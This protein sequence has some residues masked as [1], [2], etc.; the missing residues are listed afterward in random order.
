MPK[1]PEKYR[2]GPFWLDREK[3]RPNWLICWYDEARGR[4]KR[5]STGTSDLQSA[6]Q[7]L[8]EHHLKTLNPVKTKQ[9][10]TLR[11]IIM[12]YW[13]EHGQ[14]IHNA[15]GCKI[16]LG[17]FDNFITWSER[18]G[19]FPQDPTLENWTPGIETSFVQ[20]LKDNPSFTE[21]KVKNSKGEVVEVIKTPRTRSP[22]TINR[23][24]DDVRA[25]FNYAVEKRL[26]KWAPKFKRIPL[27][28]DEHD[29]RKPRLSMD[30]MADLF[31]YAFQ[32]SDRY[33]LQAYL[34]AAVNTLARPEAIL[35][36]CADPSRQQ[37]DL[38]ARL[39]F[40]N[41]K[42]RQQTKKYRPVVPVNDY[43]MTWLSQAQAN[44]QRNID[45]EDFTSS[46]YL[47]E[48][49]GKSLSSIRQTW[50]KAK[51]SLGWPMVRDWDAKMI[52]HTVATWIRSRGGTDWL[53]LKA[54]LGHHK[55]DIS[56][57]YAIYEPDYLGQIQTG[58]NEYLEQLEVKIKQRDA[59]IAITLDGDGKVVALKRSINSR[60]K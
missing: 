46:G 5:Q 27:D 36:I 32:S 54:Q 12:K 59:D 51:K 34:I 44:W 9:D 13:F 11:Q 2:A 45:Q 23:Y 31:V 56:E 42:G 20:Y 43:L 55:F 35:D 38:E 25:A 6:K 3:G 10:I 41:P 48:Y 8:T 52:R 50:N 16:A 24:L 19:L 7:A 37:I 47:V 15:T 33:H 26:L 49:K 57:I 60:V 17:Y 28:R 39:L 4:V 14:N 1:K 53:E 29:A 40:L 22:D 18:S 58:I 21:R 30:Q